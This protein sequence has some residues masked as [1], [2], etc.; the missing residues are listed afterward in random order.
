[1]LQ[2][3]QVTT[4]SNGNRERYNCFAATVAVFEYLVQTRGCCMVH[5]EKYSQ[6]VANTISKRAN[7]NPTTSDRLNVMEAFKSIKMAESRRLS[8]L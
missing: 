8:S 4:V 3:L 2:K 7:Q 1:M 6:G 5:K